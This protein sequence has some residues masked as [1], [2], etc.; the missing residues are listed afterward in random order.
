MLPKQRGV[1]FWSCSK[2][3]QL[4]L[5]FSSYWAKFASGKKC[6]PFPQND[7]IKETTKKEV[8]SCANLAHILRIGERST[9]LRKSCA[10]IAHRGNK[11][12][13]AH[14]LRIG[15]RSTILR[16]FCAYIAH[17]GNKYDLAQILRIARESWANFAHIL[18]IDTS[19]AQFAHLAQNTISPTNKALG[20]LCDIYLSA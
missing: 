9:I 4:L 10:Y 15:E 6:P 5:A 12:N 20:I 8:Q 13:L 19:N 11:Y 14:I 1:I 3:C 2:K 7:R 18:R 17:W 16:K